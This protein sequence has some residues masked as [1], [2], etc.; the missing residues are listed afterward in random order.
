[1]KKMLC[2]VTALMLI[3]VAIPSLA[4]VVPS[5][6]TGDLGDFIGAVNNEGQP[7]PVKIVT[8]EI[9]PAPVAEAPAA[10]TP[11]ENK[12]PAPKKLT[13]AESVLEEIVAFIADQQLAPI[14]FFDDLVREQAALLLPEGADM[15]TFELNEILPA[16]LEGYDES[17]EDVIA[18]FTFATAYLPGQTL[19]TMYGVKGEDGAMTWYPLQTVVGEDGVVQIHFTKEV[20]AQINGV[21]AVMAA[22]SEAMQEA[23]V[24]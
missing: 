8:T 3:C 15:E 22:F 18:S 9:A 10:E 1:M 16:N 23:S 11:A 20:L 7:V 19:L 5:K 4:A 6:T 2:V 14:G 12:E 21:P 17:F 24:A 13:L